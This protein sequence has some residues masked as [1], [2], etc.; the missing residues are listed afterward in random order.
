MTN[1][2]AGGDWFGGTPPVRHLDPPVPDAGYGLNNQGLLARLWGTVT[3]VEYSAPF[4]PDV[5]FI[6]D[7]SSVVGALVGTGEPPPITVFTGV[8][9]YVG[10]R[11]AGTPVSDYQISEG[12][13]VAVTGIVGSEYINASIGRIRVLRLRNCYDSGGVHPP[14][15]DEFTVIVDL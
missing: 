6:D 4:E 1:I 5:V 11:I 8:K 12:D 15:I 9:V 13:V 10:P 7:G 3:H 2:T 14:V